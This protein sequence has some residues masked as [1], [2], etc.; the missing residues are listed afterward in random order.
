M[1]F[2]PLKKNV[3]IG[4]PQK[5]GRDW[6]MT[7]PK[8]PNTTLCIGSD[9]TGT[10]VAGVWGGPLCAGHNPMHNQTNAPE[11]TQHNTAQLQMLCCLPLF[12]LD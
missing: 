9:I 8:H 5:K 12:M 7:S 1:N 2:S 4:T 11:H 10:P 6:N 3:F